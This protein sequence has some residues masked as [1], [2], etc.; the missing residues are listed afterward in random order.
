VELPSTLPPH[1]LSDITATAQRDMRRSV[2][3]SGDPE[4]LATLF[5]LGVQA[6]TASNIGEA[7]SRIH[8]ILQNLMPADVCALYLSNQET[9]TLVAT[10]VSGV[11]AEAVTGT[12]IRVGQRLSGWVAA[13]R[14][15]I[16][17]SD[18]ALDLGNLT[19]QLDP[20]PLR[21]LSTA[22]GTEPELLGVLTIY[23]TRRQPF[24]DAHVQVVEAIAGGVASLL[25]TRPCETPFRE[26]TAVPMVEP[27]SAERV[28]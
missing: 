1:V 27:A 5:E 17:N 3:N 26:A 19:M 21:C 2:A 22:I 16:V 12:T 9:D 18:A 23:S 8:A 11:H 15:T 28:H 20:M 25:R 6:A 10:F 13:N 4:T 7:L 24:T 14:Q